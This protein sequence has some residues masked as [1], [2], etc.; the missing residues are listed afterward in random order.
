M[1]D[2]G[3][4]E[5]GNFY[6]I[7]M[8]VMINCGNNLIKIVIRITFCNI[9]VYSLIKEN[10]NFNNIKMPIMIKFDN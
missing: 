7:S 9:S 6:N 10:G 8:R 5:K 3:N 4:I 2:Y 1:M